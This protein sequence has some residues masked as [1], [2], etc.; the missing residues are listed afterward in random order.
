MTKRLIAFAVVFMLL[1]SISANYV[2]AETITATVPGNGNI[3]YFSNGYHGFCLDNGKTATPSGENYVSTEGT[4]NADNNRSGADVSQHLKIFFVYCFEDIFT[5][6]ENNGYGITDSTDDNDVQKVVWHFTDGFWVSGS[7][8]AGGYIKTVEAAIANGVVIPDDG[9]QITLDNGDVITF[10]FL[11]LAPQTNTTLQDYFAYKISVGK[12]VPDDSSSEDSSDDS[13]SE[14]SSNDSSSEDS[15]VEDSSVE[16]SSVEDSSVED[17]SVEDSSVEDSSDTEPGG[18]FT[19]D[20]SAP[21]TYVAGEEVEVTV[22]VNNVTA[23]PGLH[24]VNGRLY[25]DI[26]ILGFSFELEDKDLQ[27]TFDGY[28]EWE[29]FSK[30]TT[31][32]NGDW[33]IDV[34]AAT[35]GV[36]DEETGEKILSTVTEDGLLSFT[37]KFIAKHDAVGETIVHIPDET[38]NGDYCDPE[39]NEYVEYVGTGSTDDII[40]APGDTS[41]ED[42]SNDSSVEDSSVEDS[43]D[44]SSN[45]DSSTEDSSNEDSSN[46]DSSNEDSSNEDS[47]TED[48]SNEDS[49]NEDSSNE[50]SSTED[51]STE[52]SSNEDSSNEDS[53]T[54]DSSAEDSSTEDSSDDYSDTP[55]APTD[56]ETSDGFFEDNS[57]DK[58]TSNDIELPPTGDN[59]NFWFWGIMMMTVV[60]AMYAV[61]KR[62]QNQY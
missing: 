15:S 4:L 56:D 52:D 11:V 38:V 25:F 29:G 9:Y 48:S 35:S 32:E 40:D 36:E 43:S 20:V 22:T 24:H 6:D 2:S 14:D 5:Y 12:V 13:S 44:D 1:F 30:L 8:T 26:S 53:S 61:A 21:D 45:E 41:S 17:S 58:D 42:N 37:F 57:S 23:I 28:N 18:A 10:S 50:D 60:A 62:R 19:M 59:F 46:E 16:D 33:Y 39:T 31:D 51:S 34:D 49:S 47:S 3:R 55:S 54:E 27:G 7:S